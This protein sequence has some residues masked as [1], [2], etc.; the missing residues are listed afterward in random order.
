MN[1]RYTKLYNRNG[2]SSRDI[3]VQTSQCDAEKQP[4]FTA[5]VTVAIDTSL[6]TSA[7]L[8][9][10]GFL[11]QLLVTC[12]LVMKQIAQTSYLLCDRSLC[13]TEK[14]VAVY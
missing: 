13:A 3:S 9:F 2:S 6:D 7:E 12:S 10:Y 8:R 4:C 5:Q 14:A 1:H 11:R